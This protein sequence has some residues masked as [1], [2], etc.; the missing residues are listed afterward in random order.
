MRSPLGYLAD[1]A[2][3]THALLPVCGNGSQS[4]NLV[5]L[6]FYYCGITIDTLVSTLIAILVTLLIGWLVVRSLQHGTPGKLQM[7]LEFLLDYTRGLVRETVAEDA[8]FIIPIAATIGMYILIA[9][10]ID[11][12]PLPAPL[13]HPANA[14]LNQTLAMAIVV[15]L[16]VQGY[17]IKVLGPLGYLR[18]FTKPFELPVPFRV[19]FVPL[20]IIEELVKPVTLALRLFGNMFAGLLMVYLIGLLISAA[21]SGPLLVKPLSAVGIGLLILWKAFDVFFVGTIQ[22]FIFMLLTIIYFGMAREGL[23]EE[24]HGHDPHPPAPVPATGHH[25]S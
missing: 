13:I 8:E 19:L 15:I 25:V 17:S 10:W 14:D 1:A 21:A 16:V 4:L 3:G 24:G 7:V 9:N 2:P 5:A 20:N 11:F 18:R 23:E 12:F 22:A 6:R